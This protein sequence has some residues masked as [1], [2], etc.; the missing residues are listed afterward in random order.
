MDIT[1]LF[2][3]SREARARLEQ[4][5]NHMYR[6]AYS[7]C[8]NAALADD[9]TQ[10]ALSKAM[11]K[12]SQLRDPSSGKAWMFTI[13]SNCYRDHFRRQR[14]TEDVDNYSITLESTPE[15]ESCEQETVHKVR[16]AIACLPEGQRQ[17][18]TL[19]DLEGFSYVEVAGIL[20]IPI[21]TVMSRLCRARRALKGHLLQ[22]FEQT[23]LE[24]SNHLT[25]S[26]IRRIK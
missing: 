1:T 25:T 19:V 15:T 26:V 14:E 18:V 8:H 6:V 21:G 16:A 10:E 9:I 23:D 3:R 24:S 13:L 5:R 11:Q 22:E 20:D 17:V 7:W 2:S 12:A 4:H